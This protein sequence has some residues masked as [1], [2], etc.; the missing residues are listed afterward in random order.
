MSSAAAWIASGI[1]LPAAGAPLLLHSAFRPFGV[2]CR[3][4]LA[5]AAGALV[6]SWTMTVLTLAHVPWSVP[7]LVLLAAAQCFA[8]RLALGRG[9]SARDDETRG[10]RSIPFSA[11]ERLGIAVCAAALLAAFAAALA[12]AATSPDLLL[13]WGPKGEAF[14][15]AR[16]IDDGFLGE[17]FLRYLHTSYPPLVTNLYAFATLAAGKLPWMAAAATSPLLLCACAAA[18]PGILRSFTGRTEAIAATAAIAASLGFLSHSL[19]IA[20]N[21]DMALLLFQTLAI[22]LLLG[23][24]AKKRPAQLLA[25]LLFAGAAAA[26]VEGLP[27]VLAAGALFLWTRRRSVAWP[28]A[29]VLLFA[30]TALSLGAWFLFGRTTYLFGW[31]EGYGPTLEVHWERLPLVIAGIGS[32][33][34]RAGA[35][36]AWLVPLV[37]WLVARSRSRGSL[38]PV[39]LAAVLS[40]FFVFTYLH[41]GQDPTL[42][43]GWSAGRIFMVLAPLFVLAAV[44]RPRP[45]LSESGGGEERS[46]GPRG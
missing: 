3:A 41:G 20:G 25:G 43:I 27:F 11:F 34:W 35:A 15:A 42:W 8:L 28:S 2:A 4:V 45:A 31:Y 44:S 38:S 32:A 40:V 24:D 16:R 9:G 10:A 22:A 18:L 21:A 46:P 17:P 5:G 33:M 7:L 39:V 30:P 26:K 14:A 12:A 1:A 19:E 6:L 13:F 29:F 36:L 37:A 23:P